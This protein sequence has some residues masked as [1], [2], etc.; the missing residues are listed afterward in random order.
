MFAPPTTAQRERSRSSWQTCPQGAGLKSC[1]DHQ[2]I[3]KY[4][5]QPMS[6]NMS[7]PFELL[8]FDD[9]SP[10]LSGCR[11]PGRVRC[12]VIGEATVVGAEWRSANASVTELGTADFV[13]KSGM[14]SE[15]G[16][17][18]EIEE[19]P[20]KAQE[21]GLWTLPILEKETKNRLNASVPPW[22]SKGS[23]ISWQA[24]Q[25]GDAPKMLSKIK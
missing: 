2:M 24:N 25:L 5:I 10:V 15:N 1:L 9:A 19:L 4:N 17:S 6:A 21:L 11:F 14:A 16:K 12:R 23:Q 7:H 22:S 13:T 18:M 20:K 8:F 3:K